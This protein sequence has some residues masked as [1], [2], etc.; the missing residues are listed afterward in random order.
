MSVRRITGF[1]PDPMKLFSNTC[2]WLLR[3]GHK[4]LWQEPVGA[5]GPIWTVLMWVAVCLGIYIVIH[6]GLAML[7]FLGCRWLM[8]KI[9]KPKLSARPVFRR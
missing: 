4:W 3:E 9:G 1:V 2:R 6:V 5:R 8:D 7:A